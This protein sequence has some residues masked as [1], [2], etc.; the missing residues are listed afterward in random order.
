MDIPTLRAPTRG[1]GAVMIF[2]LGGRVGERV[3]FGALGSGH[4][5]AG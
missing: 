2:G 5:I 3:E 1:R 4:T